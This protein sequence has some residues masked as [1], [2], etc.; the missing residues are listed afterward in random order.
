MARSSDAVAAFWAITLALLLVSGCGDDG[1]GPELGPKAADFPDEPAPDPR[2]DLVAFVGVNVVHP[3]SG[4][5]QADQ[6]VLIRGALERDAFGDARRD[7]AI[8]CVGGWGEVR[9]HP[10]R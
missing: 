4:A 1:V 9:R 7:R 3:E 6:T 2:P 8:E 5:V 10:Q